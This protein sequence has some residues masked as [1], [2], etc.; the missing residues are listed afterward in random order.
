MAMEVGYS[1]AAGAQKLGETNAFD[2]LNNAVSDLRMVQ[3]RAKEIA[4]KLVGAVPDV[5]GNATAML[6]PSG[7]IGVVD[8][9]AGLIQAITR[10]MEE[11]L[12]RIEACI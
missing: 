5:A 7:L 8:Q 10:D 2:R 4:D 12:R 3:G 9:Q 6:V 11:S 1:K